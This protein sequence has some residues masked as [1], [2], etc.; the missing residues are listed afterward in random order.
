MV[1]AFVL[2]AAGLTGCSPGGGAKLAG[3]ERLSDGQWPGGEFVVS[4]AEPEHLVPANATTTRDGQILSALF[5]GLVEYDLTT[6]EPR[7]AMAE[8]IETAD[9]QHRTTRIKPG[10]TFHTA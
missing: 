10:G 2:L 1:L 8:S 7:N 5:T 9:H 4:A 6:A 3:G